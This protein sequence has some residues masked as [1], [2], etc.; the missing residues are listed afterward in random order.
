MCPSVWYAVLLQQIMQLSPA[1]IEGLPPEQKA[2]VL[3]LQQQMVRCM[4]CKFSRLF[5]IS[6]K[7]YV[8][9]CL[10]SPSM[11]ADADYATKMCFML[12]RESFVSRS[13]P[14]C[15][16]CHAVAE[17]SVSGMVSLYCQTHMWLTCDVLLQRAQP[18]MLQ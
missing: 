17:P 14:A 8:T 10:R 4:I 13:I 7:A 12:L 9:S 2:Q 5:C 6:N 3:A 18:S 1:Q 15:N 11:P 16:G